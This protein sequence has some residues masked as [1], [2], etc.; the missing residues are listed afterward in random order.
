MYFLHQPSDQD[1]RPIYQRYRSLPL[2]YPEVSCTRGACPAGYVLDTYRVRLGNGKEVFEQAKRALRQWRMLRLGWV[3]P[4]WPDVATAEGA[5]I[6]TMA[7]VF[8]LWMV[9][10]CRIVHVVDEGGPISRYGLAYG[11]LPGHAE[12]GEEQFLVEWHEGDDS[13]WYEILAISKPGGWLARLAYPLTRRL[14]RRFGQ[15]SL[16]AM[17][18]AVGSEESWPEWSGQAPLV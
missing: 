9:N 7:R 18:T 1:L 12:C 14:Q 16:K 8:G 6:G 15:D 5:L 3:R 17:V 4:C 13:V 11:T 2:S 10:V